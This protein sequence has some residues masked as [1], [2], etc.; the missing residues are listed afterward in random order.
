LGDE[1]TKRARLR[2]DPS[3][4]ALEILSI[5]IAIVLATA[6]G[7]LVERNRAG[8]RTHEALSQICQEISHDDVRLLAVRPLHVRVG[9]AFERTLEGVRGEQLEFDRFAQT[10]HDA[11]PRGF[12]PFF[13]TTTAWE[14]A[15][16][17][18]ALADVPYALR[19]TLVNRYGQLAVLK[20]ENTLVLATLLTAPT[21]QHPNFFFV[22][23]SLDD[24][25]NDV[26]YAERQLARDDAAA[27][28]VLRSAS[29]C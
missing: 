4:L 16:S 8:A 18:D 6:V 2:I 23:A 29:D 13:G 22:A 10:F 20:D 26:T 19:A 11:A 7:G 3:D 1:G 27:L 17:S 28:G 21:E 5:V 9:A 25:L 14:L 15:R 24:T 12:Q